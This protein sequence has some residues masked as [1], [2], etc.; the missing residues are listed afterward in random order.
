LLDGVQNL[1]WHVIE[2]PGFV[3]IGHSEFSTEELRF[4]TSPDEVPVDD[5][6]PFVLL[7]SVLQY[8]ETPDSTLR[9]L[10]NIGATHLIIDRTPMSALDTHRLCIQRVPKTIYDASYPCWILS[11]S[12]L[13]ELL[14]RAG[15]RVMAEF[16][17]LDGAFATPCDVSFAFRGVIAEHPRGT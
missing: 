6:P 8:L 7:S 1:R 16:D 14:R 10:L 9:Q 17:A 11:R 3:E 2:Q 13:L 12:R 4:A 5:V 15:W